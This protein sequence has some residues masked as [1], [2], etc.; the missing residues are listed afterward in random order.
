MTWYI[1]V[2]MSHEASVASGISEQSQITACLDYYKELGGSDLSAEHFP[3]DAPPGVFVDRAQ[4][5][6]KKGYWALD[7]RPAGQMLVSKLQKGDH[8]LCYNIERFARNTENCLRMLRELDDRGINVHFCMERFDFTTAAG[9]LMLSIWAAVAQY[10]SDIKSERTREALRIKEMFGYKGKQKRDR[11]D[12]MDSDLPINQPSKQQK[13]PQHFSVHIYNRISQHD[14]RLVSLGMDVQREANTRK[15]ESIAATGENVQIFTYEDDSVSAFNVP[16]TKRPAASKLLAALKP[17]DHV[18]IYRGDRAFRNAR[19]CCEFVEL[20]MKNKITVH[21][22]REGAT[23]ADEYGRLFFK[24]LAMFAEI[25]S[26]MRRKQKLRMNEAMAARGRPIAMTPRQYKVRKINGRKQLVYDFKELRRMA[27]SWILRSMGYEWEQ[28]CR[29][30]QAY[31]CMEKNLK[32]GLVLQPYD[33]VTTRRR[34]RRFKEILDQ[35]GAEVTSE[36]VADAV[37]HLSRPI[38]GTYL[39]WCKHPVP[40]L[41]TWDRLNACGIDS[42]YLV[43]LPDAPSGPAQSQAG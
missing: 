4:S 21:L 26:E 30:L 28:V 25:E 16:F 3:S 5:A 17:G 35:L 38:A 12:W 8:I 42:K 6:W 40:I 32:P 7:Q 41:C 9:K 29:T 43:L 11:I 31:H 23:T 33:N 15:A 39:S 36:L 19:Q 14:H 37:S 2:R 1:Y 27:R 34:V 18:V 13:A 20:C 22:T 24:V 10:Q